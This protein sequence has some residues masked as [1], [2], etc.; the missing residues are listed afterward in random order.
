[1]ALKI[2]SGDNKNVAKSIGR[3]IG[4]ASPKVLTGKELAH[5]SPEALL[6][7]VRDIDIFA[8]IEPQ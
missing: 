6:L 5:I 2:I 8:E 3:Q 1:M 4:I 7:K